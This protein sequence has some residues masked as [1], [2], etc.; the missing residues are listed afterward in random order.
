MNKLEKLLIE[1]ISL[2]EQERTEFEERIKG[3]QKILDYRMA[4]NYARD[5]DF[6]LSKKS[7]N[8]HLITEHLVYT[9]KQCNSTLNYL[10]KHSLVEK[11]LEGRTCYRC[12][13][14]M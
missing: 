6:L 7:L 8:V 10:A 11:K 13:K 5:S 3:G 1:E 2:A 12:L 4:L 14:V 9:C